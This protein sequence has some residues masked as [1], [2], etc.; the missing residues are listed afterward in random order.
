[1]PRMQETPRDSNF[2]APFPLPDAP[3]NAEAMSPRDG[4]NMRLPFI[5][6]A[7]P[8]AL[9]VVSQFPNECR[10]IA[11]N[12]ILTPMSVW[13]VLRSVPQRFREIDS[14]DE[15][16]DVHKIRVKAST[17]DEAIAKTTGFSSR[18][19]SV[20]EEITVLRRP[21]TAGVRPDAVTIA[22]YQWTADDLLRFTR[23]EARE[24]IGD[25]ATR[26][27]NG[28]RDI[29]DRQ[30]LEA[31]MA[32]PRSLRETLIGSATETGDRYRRALDPK[33][34]HEQVW[35]EWIADLAE[36]QIRAATSWLSI[37]RHAIGA[38]REQFSR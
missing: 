12:C 16:S 36:A 29:E 34:Y 26:L 11:E 37:Q 6:A 10:T 8:E 21:A 15:H 2:T 9:A 30:L 35:L 28:N 14:S 32:A 31:V 33:R 19:S 23:T 18:V 5:K 25:A 22:I 4:A 27:I 1:M 24:K 13:N 3:G 7:T 17:L 20:R 38:P